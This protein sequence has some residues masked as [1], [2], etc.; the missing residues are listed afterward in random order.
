[1]K[2]AV[3]NLSRMLSTSPLRSLLCVL[4]G[5]VAI[6]GSPCQAEEEGEGAARMVVLDTTGFWRHYNVFAPPVIAS[7]NGTE[8]LQ[9]L[10]GLNR[11]KTE[12][13]YLNWETPPVPAD[14][15]Q[16]DFDDSAWTRGP[17]L[18]HGRVIHLSRHYLRG[19]FAIKDVGK[20]G[21]LTLSV[22]YAGGVIVRVNGKEVARQHLAEGAGLA[23]AY[24]EE[25]FVDPDGKLLD[26]DEL[27]K[28]DTE[29][30]QRMALRVRHL[31]GVR[32]P[33]ALLRQGTN[34]IA[35]EIVRSPYH[36]SA[37][38]ETKQW[39]QPQMRWITCGVRRVQLVT[40]NADG[41]VP[42]A[43]R[44]RGFQVWNNDIAWNDYDLDFGDPCEP[45]KP[46]RIVA[47]RNGWFSGKVVVGSDRPINGLAT[48]A[49]DLRGKGGTLPA[50]EI[51]IRYGASWTTYPDSKFHVTRIGGGGKYP[52]PYP[53]ETFTLDALL[54]APLKNYP[55][56]PEKAMAE[57]ANCVQTPH[58]PLPVP[59]AVVPIWVTVHVPGNAKGGTYSGNVS[60]GADGE[61][62]VVVP[63]EVT[64]QDWQ[65]PAP[66][67]Y[68]T[69]VDLI[70]FPDTLALEYKCKL[71]S[72]EHFA[73]IAKS[74]SL[75][76]PLGSRV[77]LVPL[78]AKTHLGNEESMVRWIPKEDGG[79]DFDF[80]V[81][82]RY[83]DIAERHMGRPKQVVFVANDDGWKRA[84]DFQDL[85]TRLDPVSG[86]TQDMAVPFFRQP[87]L[88][89]PHW[90]RL[91]DALRQ[92]MKTRD[93]ENAMILG[94]G[95]QGIP[96][97]ENVEFLK[98]VTGDLEW[99]YLSHWP[100][101]PWKFHGI[102]R[103]AYQSV[104]R[105][106]KAPP[107]GPPEYS[108]FG[109]KRLELMVR[110]DRV[111]TDE[112]VFSRGVTEYAIAGD[113][114]G[115]GW[116]GADLWGMPRRFRN[117]EG[118]I[119]NRFP[120]KSWGNMNMQKAFLAPGPDGPVAQ[121]AFEMLREGVQECEARILV[122]QALV[123]EKSRAL[124]GT[125]LV[126]RCEDTLVERTLFLNVALAMGSNPYGL[127]DWDQINGL[128]PGN[129]WFVHSNWQSRTE[130]LF[131]L[132]GE[133]AKRLEGSK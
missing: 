103:V 8:R 5:V 89:G 104:G 17:A 110:G 113:R 115:I 27:P 58:Q 55:V 97:K 4:M 112:L 114:R 71:W 72:D 31:E 63:V 54:D 111:A 91:F 80:S 129:C 107:F 59:G 76:H 37:K 2:D 118:I 44:P 133:V 1:M 3:P 14:W 23:E 117:R 86:A 127:E 95:P 101:P 67:E 90:M 29:V 46:V 75:L 32:I 64:V 99:N 39:W 30:P 35:L 77:V 16:P 120:E 132:A 96:R 53:V 124:L 45:L 102:A 15:S 119:G 108:H 66:Q 83:L 123:G 84:E 51:R 11:F 93:L 22:S 60:I 57:K 56:K 130:K 20:A 106:F 100:L 33:A 128:Q 62:N 12:R 38:P 43:V 61:G 47:T 28:P 6:A 78:L 109:W 68:K 88:G 24:P 18:A 36:K 65:L 52:S 79:Y 25:A 126:K 122:E 98:E 82:D 85:V 81:M 42:G 9:D 21:N 73:L 34:V 116:F 50:S 10:F 69:W 121:S 125:E 74:M 70:E 41:V 49:G 48:K 131:A 92:R 94:L 87:E 19:K 26:G 7:E 13:Y 105:D 40:D